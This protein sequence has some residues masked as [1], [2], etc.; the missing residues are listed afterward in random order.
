M[1]CSQYATLHQWLCLGASGDTLVSA[2]DEQRERERLSLNSHKEQT[3]AV[4][5]KAGVCRDSPSLFYCS[6]QMAKI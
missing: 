1:R 2:G 6:Q 4:K 5:R 3:V